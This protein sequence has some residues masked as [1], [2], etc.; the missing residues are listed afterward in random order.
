MCHK[1]LISSCPLPNIHPHD[2]AQDFLSSSTNLCPLIARLFAVVCESH[3]YSNLRS[4]LYPL[5]RMT[6]YVSLTFAYW[7]DIFLDTEFHGF[8]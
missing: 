5:R 1:D 8:P 4:V 6:R 7:E 3:V 2:S